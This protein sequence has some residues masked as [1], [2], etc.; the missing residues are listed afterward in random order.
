MI[1]EEMAH[2][3]GICHTMADI[4]TNESV[5]QQL[6]RDYE[7]YLAEGKKVKELPSDAHT[8]GYVSYNN[9]GDIN[10]AKRRKGWCNTGIAQGYRVR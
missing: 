2:K 3:L 6:Q 1:T 7:Q 9:Q 4:R 5:R 8:E 10:P